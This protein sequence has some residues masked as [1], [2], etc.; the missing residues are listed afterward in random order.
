MEAQG[1]DVSNNKIYQDNMSAML[2]KKN[3]RVSSSKRTKHINVR[4]F[5]VTDRIAK[6]DVSVVY[7]PTDKM[8]A[9]FFTKS[10]QGFKFTYFRNIVQNIK[11]VDQHH[12]DVDNSPSDHG[13]DQNNDI[14]RMSVLD[15]QTDRGSDVQTKLNQPHNGRL[16]VDVVRKEGK[17]PTGHSI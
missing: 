14:D 3:G 4:F 13:S 11:E 17:Q 2:L 5:F 9:D 7:C 12:D 1:Y 8:I 15:V 6:G 10:L 16:W